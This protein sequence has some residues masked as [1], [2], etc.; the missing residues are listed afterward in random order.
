MTEHQQTA[1]LTVSGQQAAAVN[2]DSA[3]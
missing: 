2:G 1:Q 3:V